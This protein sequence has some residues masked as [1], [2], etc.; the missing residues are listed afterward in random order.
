M[1]PLARTTPNQSCE[2]RHPPELQLKLLNWVEHCRVCSRPISRYQRQPSTTGSGRTVWVVACNYC[3]RHCGLCGQPPPPG[4]FLNWRWCPD[5]DNQPSLSDSQLVKP[6]GRD[7][8]PQAIPTLAW[9]PHH[10]QPLTWMDP[11]LVCQNCFWIRL[12]RSHFL[13]RSPVPDAI[14]AAL[15]PTERL[16][17]RHQQALMRRLRPWRLHFNQ[18]ASP[19]SPSTAPSIS[20]HF[21]IAITLGIGRYC[22]WSDIHIKSGDLKQHQPPWTWVRG[23]YQ[24]HNLPSVLTC[25]SC[26]AVRRVPLVNC[27]RVPKRRRWLQRTLARCH[28]CPPDSLRPIKYRWRQHHWCRINLSTAHSSSENK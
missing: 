4:D 27:W 9:Q 21:H 26:G 1:E 10:H 12:V 23:R 28:H 5:R 20:I 19:A 24:P 7:Y 3:L 17:G 13:A 8:T 18:P 6:Q 15:S 11:P 22:P 14:F 25:P 2:T 16:Q